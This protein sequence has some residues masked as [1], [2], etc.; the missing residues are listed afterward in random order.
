MKKRVSRKTQARSK[1]RPSAAKRG[2]T[3]P[4][5]AKRGPTRPVAA[6][7][8][9]APP[10]LVQIVED[11]PPYAVVSIHE[12][13]TE[14]SMQRLF[15][16]GRGELLRHQPRRVLLDLR[17]AEVKLSISDMNALVKL[18]VSSFAGSVE[19]L[20]I[21]LRRVDEPPEKFVEPSLTHRGLPTFATSDMDD[22]VGWIMAKLL[23]PR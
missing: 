3:R 2:P 6:E 5:A 11:S 14:S 8:G 12:P 20:A 23:R 16:Y 19:R 15:A 4:S 22:A 21:V 18:I 1:A 17:D 9:P 13:V 10:R 7:P